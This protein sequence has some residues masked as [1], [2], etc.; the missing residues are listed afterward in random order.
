MSEPVVIASIVA[1]WTG[2]GAL[3][4]VVMGRRGHSAT[5]WLVMG[6]LLGPFAIVLALASTATEEQADEWNA[7]SSP[8]SGGLHLVVGYDGSATSLEAARTASTLLAGRLDSLTLCTVVPFGE[9]PA[10]IAVAES[11]LTAAASELG[12]GT[13]TA[14]VHGHPARALIDTAEAGGF[15]ILVVGTR[16]HGLSERLLGSAATELAARSTVPTLVVPAAER[17]DSGPW[18]HD[19]VTFGSGTARSRAG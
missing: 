4:S 5:T 19:E 3:L 6:V 15:D 14:V 7:T 10:N 12:A 9:V 1:G 18:S 16:G 8:A 13:V 17:G 11:R 2:I